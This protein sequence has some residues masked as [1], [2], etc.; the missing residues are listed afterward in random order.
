MKKSFVASLILLSLS[1]LVSPLS[2]QVSVDDVWGRTGQIVD[3][4]EQQGKQILFVQIDNVSRS[5]SKSQTYTVNT[6]REYTIVAVGD[7]ARIKD[8]DLK[9]YE[10]S[11]S[12]Y[13]YLL[14]KD[15][16][17]KNVAVVRVTPSRTGRLKI[18]VSP[19]AMVN[20]TVNDGFY[21]IVVARN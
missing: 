7:N 14:A 2:A 12:G 20:N 9:V 5:S 15:E 3:L 1:G 10:I 11:S 6:G 8:L 18:V 4:V 21:S 16:D 13:E 19:Y 17:E